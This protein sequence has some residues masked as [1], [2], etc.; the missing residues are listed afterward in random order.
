MTLTPVKKLLCIVAALLAAL[1]ATV[2]VFEIQQGMHQPAIYG[3]PRAL[4]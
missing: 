1:V 2:A 3:S 4:P